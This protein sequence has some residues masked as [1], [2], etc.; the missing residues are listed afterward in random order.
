MFVSMALFTRD[1]GISIHAGT[2]AFIK[3]SNESLRLFSLLFVFIDDM[4]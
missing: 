4:S 3:Q 1:T 2:P